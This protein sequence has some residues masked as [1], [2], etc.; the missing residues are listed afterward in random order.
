MI[1]FI[2]CHENVTDALT[3]CVDDVNCSRRLVFPEAVDGIRG[4]DQ[5]FGQSPGVTGVEQMRFLLAG[6]QR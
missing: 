5:I 4:G 1:S 3:M 6:E 2:D